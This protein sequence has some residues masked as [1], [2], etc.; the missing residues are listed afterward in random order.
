M[1]RLLAVVWLVI[2]VVWV[3]A[4]NGCGGSQE[5]RYTDTFGNQG[6]ADHCYQ[7]KGNLICVDGDTTIQVAQYEIK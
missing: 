4:N 7:Q 6:I 3:V 1:A 2:L 5:Y